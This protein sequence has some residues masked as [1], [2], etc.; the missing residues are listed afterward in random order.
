[1]FRILFLAAFLAMSAGV[2]IG[3]A[4]ASQMAWSG[5]GDEGPEELGIFGR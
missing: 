1:M 3:A 5:P 2:S 4:E